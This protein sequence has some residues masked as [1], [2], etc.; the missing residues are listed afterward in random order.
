MMEGKSSHQNAQKHEVIRKNG[1][2]NPSFFRLSLTSIGRSLRAYAV[3]PC[4]LDPIPAVQP[5]Q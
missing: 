5:K 3:T 1:P 4:Q 2:L